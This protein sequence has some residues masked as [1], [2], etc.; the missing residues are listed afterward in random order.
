MNTNIEI[1]KIMKHFFLEI[2]ND[3]DKNDNDKKYK[4]YIKNK[5]FCSI[6]EINICEIIKTIPYYFNNYLIVEDYDFIGVRQLNNQII[7]KLN[8]NEKNIDNKY[9]LLKYRNKNTIFFNDFIFNFKKPKKLIFYLINIFSTLLQRL[10][11]LN[12]KDIC[13]FN[14]SYKNILFKNDC[15]EKLILSDFHLSLEISKLTNTYMMHIINSLDDFSLKPLEIYVLF[16]IIKKDIQTISYAFIEEV[17]E[18]YIKNLN[19][20]KFFSENYKE[21]YKLSCIEILKKYINKDKREIIRDIISKNQKWDIFSLSQL[22]LFIFG[23]ISIAFSLKGTFINKLLIDLSKNIHP[24]SSKRNSL[25][26]ALDNFNKLLNTEKDWSFVNNLE[27][28][29]INKLFNV[30]SN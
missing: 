25:E 4:L 29:N 28:N 14:L 12:D 1:S 18:I 20:L 3:N 24:D 27:D 7:E 2:K 9:L 8:L 11:E 13:F 23:N 15:R 26:D 10:I 22:F 19:I 17:C 5:S 16:Y 6:N 30:L 21:N